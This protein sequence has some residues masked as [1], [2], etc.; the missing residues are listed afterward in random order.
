MLTLP[1]SAKLARGMCWSIKLS[2]FNSPLTSQTIRMI[3]SLIAL[4]FFTCG[5]GKTPA[6]LQ[7]FAR[8][9]GPICRS[10]ILRSMFAMT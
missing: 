7:R 6:L 8:H 10:I 4:F 5:G 2:G 3:V 9:I 1:G